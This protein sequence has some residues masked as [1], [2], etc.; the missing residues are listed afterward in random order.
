MPI[1][2]PKIAEAMSMFWKEIEMSRAEGESSWVWDK[3]E[4]LNRKRNKTE[5]E[6]GQLA[7]L[8]A[9][10]NVQTD[11]ELRRRERFERYGGLESTGWFGMF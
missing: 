5:H 4:Q 1:C 3:I 11:H 9:L 8:K 7:E 10:A 6:Q 2:E